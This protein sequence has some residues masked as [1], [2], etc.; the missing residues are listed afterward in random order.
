MCTVLHVI[1]GNHWIEQARE[2]AA[3]VGLEAIVWEDE[4]HRRTAD[5]C[6]DMVHCLCPVDIEATMRG[7]GYSVEFDDTG[8]ATATLPAPPLER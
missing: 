4:P 3:I 2:L 1:D 6:G 7:K 5:Q 8:D